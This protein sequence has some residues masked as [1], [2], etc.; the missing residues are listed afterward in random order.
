M[1]WHGLYLL[2]EIGSFLNYIIIIKTEIVF[3]QTRVTLVDFG[4]HV[5]AL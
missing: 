2:L 5:L 1:H 3:P 4:Y